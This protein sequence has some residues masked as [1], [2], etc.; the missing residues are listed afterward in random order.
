MRRRKCYWSEEFYYYVRFIAN[1]LSA[2]TDFNFLLAAGH[3][4]CRLRCLAARHLENSSFSPVKELAN[5]LPPAQVLNVILAHPLSTRCFKPN[6]QVSR[7]AA[8]RAL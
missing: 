3:W 2:P 4:R 6:W 8:S 7:L 5:R 1:L